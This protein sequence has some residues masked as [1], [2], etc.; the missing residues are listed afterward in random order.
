[1]N[2]RGISVAKFIHLYDV[3]RPIVQQNNQLWKVY[4]RLAPPMTHSFLRNATRTR[5]P[6]M[7]V[8]PANSNTQRLG[9][10]GPVREASLES[11]P[12]SIPATE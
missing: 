8:L 9:A 11:E 5:H 4:L 1:M 6:N 7:Y 3:S 2:S 12:S 10:R